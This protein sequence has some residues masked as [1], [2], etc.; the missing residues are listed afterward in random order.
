M[1]GPPARLVDIQSATHG[2]LDDP[3]RHQLYPIN[4]SHS[5]LV[6]FANPYV[7]EY[8]TVLGYLR[9]VEAQLDRHEGGQYEALPRRNFIINPANG[10]S[11]A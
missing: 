1:T 5:N 10:S 3:D 2:R 6:K 4:S 8:G 7:E 9:S 11:T